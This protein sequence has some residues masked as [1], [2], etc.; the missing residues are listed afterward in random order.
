MGRP[1]LFTPAARGMGCRS[2]QHAICRRGHGREPTSLSL[3][4][5]CNIEA[6]KIS[7]GPL[8]A[9]ASSVTT[10]RRLTMGYARQFTITAAG[11]H[12]VWR[13]WLWAIV[14]TVWTTCS[15][16]R[17]LGTSCPVSAGSMGTAAFPAATL[18]TT[19]IGS[20]Q[21]C[22]SILATG[23]RTRTGLWRSRYSAR[24]CANVWCQ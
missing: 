8:G 9:A 12:R 19:S 7:T 17:S 1:I 20:R 3:G 13:Q 2:H 4:P 6:S 10:T 18:L 22:N 14:A 24:C 21:C 15:E 16:Q 11:G 23:S 5:G